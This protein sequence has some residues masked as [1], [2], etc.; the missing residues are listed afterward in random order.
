MLL[1]QPWGRCNPGRCACL[2]ILALLI[3]AAGLVLLLVGIFAPLDYWDFFVYSGALILAFSLLFW[4][5]W[6]SLNIELSLEKLDL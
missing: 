4:I 1:G 2:L 6:Y 3:D 5:I